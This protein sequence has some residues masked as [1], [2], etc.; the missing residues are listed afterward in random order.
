MD[1]DLLATCLAVVLG[2]GATVLA[3]AFASCRG[4]LRQEILEERAAGLRLWLPLLPAAAAWSFV[5]GWTLQEPGASDERVGLAWIVAALAFGAVVARSALRAMWSAA[6]RHT[7][8]AATVGLLRPRVVIS[9]E[10]S[11]RLDAEALAAAIAHEVAHARHRD[12]L[13]LLAGQIAADLQWPFPGARRRLAEWREAIELARDDEARRAGVPG[14]DLA[15][16]ILAAVALHRPPASA[17]LTGD[18]EGARL[19]RRI[20]RLLAPLPEGGQVSRRWHPAL[21][22]PALVAIVTLGVTVGDDV[23]N[24]LPGIAR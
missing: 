15:H 9:Q 12:P 17:A 8:A 2:G 23:L 6:S 14:D 1:R 3:A 16:A 10:L 21:L 7:G 19:R 20:E 5:L 11:E 24:L 18:E 13:W 4:S 22:V